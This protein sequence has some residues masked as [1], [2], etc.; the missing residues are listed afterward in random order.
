MLNVYICM[1]TEILTKGCISTILV[2][3]LFL[4]INNHLIFYFA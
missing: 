3:S 4:S 1:T 2:H